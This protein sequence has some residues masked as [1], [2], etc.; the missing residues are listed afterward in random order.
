M[1]TMK[2]RGDQAETGIFILKQEDRRLQRTEHPLH[3]RRGQRSSFSSR[4]RDDIE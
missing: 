3:P 2:V 1:V 4:S